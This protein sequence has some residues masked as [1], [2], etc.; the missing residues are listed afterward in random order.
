MVPQAFLTLVK[1]FE[2]L[3]LQAYL[4]P[5]GIP[6]I[7]YGHTGKEVYIGMPKISVGLAERLLYEDTLY[8]FSIAA[9]ISPCLRLYPEQHVAIADFIYNLGETRYKASTLRKKVEAF[10]WEAAEAELLKWVLGGGKRLP[11][12]VKRRRLEA[13]LLR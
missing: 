6:T 13:T 10:Q 8:Y 9:K 11:G 7:G 2:G 3:S 4:C 1:Y 5:A 12:L